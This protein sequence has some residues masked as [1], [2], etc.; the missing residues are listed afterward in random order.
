MRIINFDEINQRPMLSK[1]SKGDQ[2][3][4]SFEGEW[5]KIDNFGYESF[6]EI[7]ISRLM[8]KSNIEQ[9]T[10]YEPVSVIFGGKLNNGCVSRDFLNKNE[11][12]FTFER[13]HILDRGESLTGMIENMTTVQERIEYTASFIADITGCSESGYI[14]TSWI[15]SD[16]LFLNEDRHFNNMA[17]IRNNKTKNWRLCPLFDNGLALLSDINEYPL[18]V[19]DSIIKRKVKAKPFSTSFIKQV[20]EAEK[21]FGVQLKINF[22]TED[23]AREIESL[24]DIYDENILM[25]VEKLIISQMRKYSRFF[26]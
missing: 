23:V 21:L 16:A 18:F 9:V 2:A 26:E 6:S 17:A 7:L 11:E 14:I 24:R 5:Y 10:E 4:W 1:S 25:R 12:L 3:K 13:L 8:K 20:E 22:S 19:Q 15:E